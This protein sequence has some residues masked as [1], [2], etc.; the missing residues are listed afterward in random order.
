MACRVIATYS[1]AAREVLQNPAVKTVSEE[2]VLQLV[3]LRNRKSHRR[4]L[5]PRWL[6][7]A[8]RSR[9]AYSG[10]MMLEEYVNFY[11]NL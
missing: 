4:Y 9:A 7:S 8:Q 3:Q 1:D 6:S 11:Q 2:D 10:Q 5:V